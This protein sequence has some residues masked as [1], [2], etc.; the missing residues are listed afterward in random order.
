MSE[1]RDIALAPIVERVGDID[2]L[3]VS[4]N[5]PAAMVRHTAEARSAGIP[6]AADPSQQIASLDGA[7]L[8][9]LVDGAA[10]LLTNDYERDL[11]VAK[12]GWDETEV[13][14]RVGIR[15]TT[16]GAHGIEIAQAG[17]PT[18]HVPVVP[19]RHTADPTGVGDAFRA[20]LLSGLAGGL[21]VEPAA[22]LG[23]LLATYALETTG[24]QEYSIDRADAVAR[25][26]QAY[27]HA[28]TE[29]IAPLLPA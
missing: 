22:R 6:F 24:T 19:A 10:Y 11:L 27:G 9:D 13:G 15:V 16:L 20:G 12:T 14:R 8:R 7:Q 1:A 4:P 18:V 17:S 25:L 21:A 29:Q 28:A 23:A 3:V 26:A 5:D 2:L